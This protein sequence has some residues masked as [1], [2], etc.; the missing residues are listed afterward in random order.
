MRDFLRETE[1]RDKIPLPF[2]CT[3]AVNFLAQV[4]AALFT[5]LLRKRLSSLCLNLFSADDFFTAKGKPSK[6]KLVLCYQTL[7]E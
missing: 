7:R 1:L 5:A 2:A 6:Q 3:A 4:R